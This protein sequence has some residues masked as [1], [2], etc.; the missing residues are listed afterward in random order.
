MTGN[1][2]NG[3]TTYH[4][5]KQQVVEEWG[6]SY[7]AYPTRQYV[8]G[9]YIDECIQLTAL[10]NIGPGSLPAGDYYPLQDLLY[11]TTALTDSSGSIVEAY[12]YDAYGNTLI[13]K[14]AGTGGNWWADNAVTANYSACEVL[15]CGY[16]FDS[17]LQLYYVR[18]R[19]YNPKLGR[20]MQRDSIGFKGRDWNLYA[21]AEDGP[22]NY[23]DPYGLFSGGVSSQ[24]PMV[25]LTESDGP[26]GYMGGSRDPYIFYGRDSQGRAI[27]WNRDNNFYYNDYLLKEYGT[28]SPRLKFSRAGGLMWCGIKRNSR[29]TPNQPPNLSPLGAGRR[30]AFNE[31][32]RRNDIPVSQ[33]PRKV[34]PNYDRRGKLQPGRS[35]EFDTPDGE[36][37]IRDDA[38]GH[39][40]GEGDPQNIG[41]HFNNPNGGHYGY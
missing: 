37:T 15:Y 7:Y 36:V 2:P 11:R 30:G 27:L 3:D 32:R 5:W 12:D 35:Y 10:F 24:P 40:Y 19:E 17:E 16:R 18:N 14:S 9:Q 22:V 31:A 13:F 1:I 4:Y 33:Q 8:W 25:G 26:I 6:E 34:G 28:E 41:A 21:Y 20:W 23:V 38:G 39:N 29:E